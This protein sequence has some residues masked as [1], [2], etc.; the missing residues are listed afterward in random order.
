MTRRDKIKKLIA[1][2]V[3]LLGVQFFSFETQDKKLTI[4]NDNYVEAGAYFY[5]CS[6]KY[7]SD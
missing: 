5:H 3:F 2:V 6:S 4:K 7:F 1:F